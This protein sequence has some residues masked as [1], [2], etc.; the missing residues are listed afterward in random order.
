MLV[1]VVCGGTQVDGLLWGAVTACKVATDPEHCACS[2]WILP[3]S[4][5]IPVRTIILFEEGGPGFLK[6]AH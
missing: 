5:G 4:L 6:R 3:Y 2:W 1:V